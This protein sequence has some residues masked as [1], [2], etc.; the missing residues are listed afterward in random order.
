MNKLNIILL[1]A[2]FASGFA[3]VS[4]QN[5]SRQHFIALDKAQ[6]QEIK[7]EQDYARLK[8]EQA[9]LSNHKLIKSAAEKQNLQPPSAHNTIMVERR[10]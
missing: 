7:L 2:A 3:V 5:Q 4:V 9:R 10:K 6:K 8:L 1:L